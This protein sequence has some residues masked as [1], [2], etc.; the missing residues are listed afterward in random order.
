[1][2]QLVKRPA[3]GFGSGHDIMVHGME[4]CV[5]LCADS[6]ELAWILSLLLPLP[7]PCLCML[8]LCSISLSKKRKKTK[9]KQ[10]TL[11]VLHQ[12]DGHVLKLH[13]ALP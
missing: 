11:N 2:A 6:M 12:A 4:S 1:M 8:V 5:G 3:L 9:D 10:K 7:L 13:Q